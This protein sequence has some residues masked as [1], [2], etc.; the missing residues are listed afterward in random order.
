MYLTDNNI[1]SL[2]TKDTFQ[3]ENESKK[4]DKSSLYSHGKAHQQL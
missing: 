3:Q 4:V 2:F 1:G